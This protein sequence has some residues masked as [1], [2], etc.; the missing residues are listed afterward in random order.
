[1]YGYQPWAVLPDRQVLVAVP[2]RWLASRGA[3]VVWSKGVRGRQ[4]A[5][6]PFPA[7]VASAGAAPG[8]GSPAAVVRHR[9]CAPVPAQASLDVMSAS[10][11]RS[12]VSHLSRG[13]A[14][15]AAAG[16]TAAGLTGCSVDSTYHLR[17][18]AE[19]V[20]HLTQRLARNELVTPYTATYQ[21]GGDAS[22]T[23]TY[24]VHPR[25]V[26]Y[27]FGSGRYVHTNRLAMFCTVAGK[28]TDC[29]VHSTPVTASRPQPDLARIRAASA[30][31]FV[32]SE[33]VI[34][35]LTRASE[36]AGSQIQWADRRIAGQQV[37]CVNVRGGHATDP[38]DACLTG[39]G[40]L[41]S[42]TGRLDGHQFDVTLTDY[43][44]HAVGRPYGIPAG[45]RVDDQRDG[46]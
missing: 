46:Q 14:L 42:F 34:S 2:G 30:Q 43:Q 41:A 6:G 16:L 28:S 8:T 40:A 19:V 12:P 15:F 10:R 11:R 25:R 39:S 24:A 13:A 31:R 20:D 18:R 3:A 36:D 38:F 5:T 23:V 21:I 26:A 35:L 4:G 17:G 9:I 27:V 22:A 33:A 1:M 7:S 44:R 32:P 37:S 45:A 29:T